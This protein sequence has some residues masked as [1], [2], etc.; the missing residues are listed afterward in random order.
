MPAHTLRGL[1][2][3]A[4]ELIATFFDFDCRGPLDLSKAANGLAQL[5]DK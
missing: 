2:N 5:V 1:A 3:R 4:T